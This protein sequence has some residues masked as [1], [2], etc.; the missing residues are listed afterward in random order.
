MKFIDRDTTTN[1]STI[2]SGEIIATEIL[3]NNSFSS[4]NNNLGDQER[5]LELSPNGRYAKFNCVL[6]KGAYKVVYKALD[7]DEGFEVA[8]NCFQ[9][10][11]EI[12]KDYKGRIS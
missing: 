11:R 8:W 2:N 7:R 4:R 9:V 1:S 12:N 3:P 6:G 10:W 5:I